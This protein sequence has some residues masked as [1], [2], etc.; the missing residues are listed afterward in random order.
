MSRIRRLRYSVTDR[1]K[2]LLLGR[3]ALEPSYRPILHYLWQSG[4]KIT[5]DLDELLIGLGS[6]PHG[7]A[8]GVVD[9]DEGAA[10]RV[11]PDFYDSGNVTLT[12]LDAL[13][14]S[15]RPQ[16]VVET[17][18]ANGASTRAILSA[19]NRNAS[20]ALYSFD[21]DPRVTKAAL[22][23]EG[24][25]LWRLHILKDHS[26]FQELKQAVASIGAPVDLWYHDSD[27][28]YSW[29]LS[30]YRL[31]FEFLRPGGFLVSDDIDGNEAFGDFL[32]ESGLLVA[33]AIF[34]TRKVCGFV[35]KPM[36]NS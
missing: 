2:L 12:A 23:H 8:P 28:S 22:G 7:I 25:N 13:V 15:H 35:Q 36:P 33:Y 17:G 29:Q 18:V 31:A 9:S 26:L 10:S 4:V 27:H 1:I 11:F 34:D 20:G 3:G 5:A 6:P 24:E 16:I 21:V 19:L 14:R 32:R 30:E